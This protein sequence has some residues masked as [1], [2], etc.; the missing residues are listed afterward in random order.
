MATTCVS[1]NM[2]YWLN[3]LKAHIIVDSPKQEIL[4]SF[5]T[6]SAAVVY[7]ADSSVESVRMSARSAA[8]TNTAR[9]ALWLKTWPGDVLR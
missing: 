9:R 8:F 7:I 3:Q 5:S 2:E 4:D 1:G 6:L